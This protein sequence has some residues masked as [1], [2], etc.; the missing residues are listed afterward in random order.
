[1]ALELYNSPVSTCSQKVR[2][3]LAEKC[4]E[5]TDRTIVFERGD[6]LSDWYLEINP[7]GV[8]PTLIHDG[9]IVTDS[10]VINEYLEDVF[11]ECPLRPTKHFEVA[12]MR[13]WRQYIDEVP[14]E[15]IRYPSF[16]AHFLRLTSTMSDREFDDYTAR[17]PL[18]KHFYRRMGRTGFPKSEI[19]AALDRLR[20]TVER[21]DNALHNTKWLAHGMF[22]LADI[23][24]MPTIV[25]MEDLGLS[26]IWADLPR[27]SAWYTRLGQRPAFATTYSSRSRMLA[28]AC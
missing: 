27:M 26:H 24:V 5:W 22:T 23:S 19:D 11:P 14:T 17:L 21:M 9:H 18:R 20:Q 6:H 25:R 4:I 15:A 28:A 2:M 8:V 3:V 1:M 10:S 16:N 13:A 12:H 7:N